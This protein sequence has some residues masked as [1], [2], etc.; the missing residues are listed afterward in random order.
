MAK[1]MAKILVA[2]G[3]K[4]HQKAGGIGEIL[5]VL[6][7]NE[8]DKVLTKR[9]LEAVQ[10]RAVEV[11]ADS[12]EV[13]L[14]IFKA[15]IEEFG[16]VL[17]PQDYVLN[18]FRIG[19]W[20]SVVRDCARP[21][22]RRKPLTEIQVEELNQLGFIW[23][24]HKESWEKHFHAAEKFKAREGH[25]K[26]P[27]NWVEDDC[28][29]GQ[30]QGVQRAARGDGS[31]SHDRIAQ[32]NRIGFIWDKFDHKWNEGISALKIYFDREGHLNMPVYHIE[33]GFALWKWLA[34]RRRFKKEGL[35]SPD[36]VTELESYGIIWDPGEDAWM[37][38]IA[39]L[40]KYVDREGNADVPV[41]HLEEGERVGWWLAKQRNK[42]RQAR[43][44]KERMLELQKLKV[45]P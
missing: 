30:W 31:I 39:L 26:I 43:L 41:E 3:K 13:G 42:M 23:D 37:R 7:G 9:L 11:S 10:L 18:G 38:W 27:P 45:L 19:Q 5:E 33:N 16:H 24:P 8:L 29:L 17:V 6:I 34:T 35:L 14:E 2:K 28:K 1:F 40:K 36:R 21:A 15:F 32:L 4:P 22:T 44:P 12:F 20:V 25:L